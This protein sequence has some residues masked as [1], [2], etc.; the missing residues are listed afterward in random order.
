MLLSVEVNWDC[1]RE[2]FRNP[3][4]TLKSLMAGMF[5][6]RM[7]PISL[8]TTSGALRAALRKENVTT[9]RSP[10]KSLMVFCICTFEGSMSMS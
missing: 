10:G 1:E 8:P 4:T 2:R 9:V 7:L 5:D 6:F 3:L